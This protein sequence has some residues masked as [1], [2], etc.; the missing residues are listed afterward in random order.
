VKLEPETLRELNLHIRL[1][2]REPHLAPLVG[3]AQNRTLPPGGVAALHIGSTGI[4]AA[5]GRIRGG[6]WLAT[7]DIIGRKY[8][9]RHN[10][11]GGVTQSGN[12]LQK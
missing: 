10:Q 9:A 2:V 11:H 8:V 5:D 7:R 3:S 12:T 4:A 6:A 1:C